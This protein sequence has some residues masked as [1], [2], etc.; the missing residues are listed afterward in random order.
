MN[1]PKT[2]PTTEPKLIEK[3]TRVKVQ[4]KTQIKALQ[5]LY[6]FGEQEA[7]LYIEALLCD[8]KVTLFG[9]LA[10]Q[11]RITFLPWESEA[12]LR[13]Y[14]S[15]RI[16]NKPNRG[17]WRWAEDFRP[18]ESIEPHRYLIDPMA[19]VFDVQR[20]QEAVRAARESG[21]KLA[22]TWYRGFLPAQPANKSGYITYRLERSGN[23]PPLTLTRGRLVA[24]RSPHLAWC[25]YMRHRYGLE[26]YLSA[27]EEVLQHMQ[28]IGSNGY[29]VPTGFYHRY[30]N[31][32]D[33]RYPTSGKVKST[34]A[35]GSSGAGKSCAVA[36][37]EV[38]HINHDRTDDRPANVRW[39]DRSMQLA[40]VET[41]NGVKRRGLANELHA[42][43]ER[44][45]ATGEVQIHAFSA[46][47]IEWMAERQ[48]L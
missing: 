24:Y 31:E 41:C 20:M 33:R 13:Q 42:L 8:D 45:L 29:P 14:P 7:A 3:L 12:Y 39:V 4:M 11:A 44:R 43:W 35:K 25:D 17:W 27:P 10:Y 16:V 9:P 38:D 15:N 19:N 23:F 47:S 46:W 5:A 21:E 2:L 1:Q 26:S 36:V 32:V 18:D 30:L 22:P 48:V 28:G 6:G 37:M 40:N 34:Y